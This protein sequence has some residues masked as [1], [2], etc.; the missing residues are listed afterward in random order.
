MEEENERLKMEIEQMRKKEGE[1]RFT[2]TQA[3]PIVEAVKGR[4]S[5]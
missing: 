1:D 4:Q 3:N 2:Q 5:H